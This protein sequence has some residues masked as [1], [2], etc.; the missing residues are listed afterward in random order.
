MLQALV[1]NGCLC[2]GIIN[3][4]L[5][6]KLQLPRIPILPRQLQTAEMSDNKPEVNSITHITLDLDGYVTSKLWLYVVP[7]S[8]HQLILGKKWLEDQDAIIHSKEQKLELRKGKKF[9]FSAKIWRQKLR[10]V[11][12]PKLTSATVMTSIMKEVPICKVSLEDI[13]KALRS[14]PHLTEREASERLP[15]Q[16][17]DYAHLFADESGADEL[18]PSRGSLDHAINLRKEDG[19][20]LSPPWGPL[21]NMSREELLVLPHLLFYLLESQMEDFDSA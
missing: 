19:K 15:E 20:A 18:P 21:Y 6:E 4:N 9:I 3:E 1:D 17:R 16:I 5:V 7:N 12:K 10:K 13:N 14:K 8:T 11:A 2:S